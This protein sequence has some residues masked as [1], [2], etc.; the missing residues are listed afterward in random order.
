MRVSVIIPSLN[1]GGFISEM[2][3]SLIVQDF[4]KDEW[5]VLIVDGGSEDNT[6]EI[7]RSYQDTCPW[8]KL[9]DNPNKVVPH[10]MNIGIRESLGDVIVRMDAHSRYPSNYVSRLLKVQEDTQADNVGGV[11]ETIPGSDSDVA[12]AIALATSH[13]FGIGN[14]A[15]RL[16]NESIKEVDTVP[17]GCY[18][19]KVF[20]QIGYYDE[21]LVRNQD[22]E[23]NGRLIAAGGKIVLIPDLKIKYSA[24]PTWKKMMRMF[25]QYG[26]YKPLVN[27]KLGKPA[28]WR[29]FIPPAFVLVAIILISSL[30]FTSTSITQLIF[31]LIYLLSA[32]GIA[33]V[34]ALRKVK[35][36]MLFLIPITFLLIHLSYGCGYWMGVWSFLIHGRSSQ[37]LNSSR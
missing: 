10:A 31:S 33:L 24:R 17:Y 32:L 2:I 20:E 25:Y 27:R 21:D 8:I 36:S 12:L 7:V 19:R 16:E 3:E 1:E 34:I 37:Y 18:P 9:L 5:E 28:T 26:M 4:P 23:L 35:F 22:D 14:A 30:F 6:R 13:P 11:W 15:Y 29:Q